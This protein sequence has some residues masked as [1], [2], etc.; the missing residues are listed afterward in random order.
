MLYCIRHL[1]HL[2]SPFLNS[3]RG[4]IIQECDSY[5][6]QVEHA[7]DLLKESI[8][9]AKSSARR[10]QRSPHG[11]TA[12]F[13]NDKAIGPVIKMLNDVYTLPPVFGK[14]PLRF[15]WS[16]PVFVCLKSSPPSERF[17]DLYTA[18]EDDPAIQSFTVPGYKYVF[19][20]PGY[21]TYPISPIGPPGRNC[22]T[23]DKNEFRYDRNLERLVDVQ[24][25]ML[26]HELVHIYLGK[27]T[28]GGRTVPKEEYDA[29]L[30]VDFDQKLS[31]RNPMNY[32]F[33]VASKSSVDITTYDSAQ[34]WL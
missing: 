21:F 2:A 34:I 5:T 23:V 18:C 32:Q 8:A 14:L 24:K 7:L 9:V 11:F 27:A 16:H 13:K 25:Y 3:S 12:F 28:L 31:L 33:F 1:H 29:N 26:L 15:K 20:C 30:C 22:P 17:G 10:G 6:D 19:L 4:Y